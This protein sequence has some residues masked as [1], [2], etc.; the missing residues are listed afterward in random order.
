M[1]K[2]VA[3]YL[4]RVLAF[5]SFLYLAF[6]ISRLDLSKLYPLFEW[7]WIVKILFLS[8]LFALSYLLNA[9]AWRDILEFLTKRELDSRVI[10]VYLETVVYKY[11]PGNVFHFLGRHSLSKTF[12]LPHKSILLTNSL[13]VLSLLVSVLILLSLLA[14]FFKIDFEF[15]GFNLTWERLFL[16]FAVFA[17]IVALFLYKKS[18]NLNRSDLSQVA[19]VIV[20][21]MLFLISSATVLVAVFWLFLGVGFGFLSFFETLFV[22]FI[23]WVLGFVVPGAPGGVGIRESV[24]ILLL[25]KVLGSGLEIVTVGVILYRV[26]TVL[27]EGMTYLFAKF[28]AKRV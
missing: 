14:L 17:L 27:G 11:L 24:L 21:N 12:D 15:M 10:R 3:T 23:A 1:L 16:I 20:K 19:G 8:A 13:E 2:R 26:I 5:A 6:V 7:S 18:T 9:F 4:G 22:A 28:R 25:P